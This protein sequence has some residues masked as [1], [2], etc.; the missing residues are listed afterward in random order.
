MVGLP[1]DLGRDIVDGALLEPGQRVAEDAVVLPVAARG[2][3]S[4]AMLR[5]RRAASACH[6]SGADAETHL[7]LHLLDHVIDVG[8]HHVDIVTAPVGKGHVHVRV[9]PQV[10]VL[11]T[12]VGGDAVGVEV[13][14]KD[15]A[16]HVIF[17]DDFFDDVDDAL[18]GLGQAG[19]ED[20]GRGAATGVG[21]Q[22]AR[23]LQFLVLLGIP[24]GAGAPA[25]G[26]HPGVAL[27]AAGM[28]LLDGILQRVVAGITAAGAGQVAGPWLIAGLVEGVAH[29]AHLQEDGIEML[30]LQVVQIG[31]ELGFL[32]RGIVDTGRPVDTI[33]RSDPCGA[34]LALQGLVGIGAGRNGQSN[35]QQKYPFHHNFDI[36]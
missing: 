1:V 31:I 22:H 12:A 3:G 9:V 18:A 23:I 11:G 25:I 6:T 20:G 21:Q 10:V 14:V 8:N 35:K 34:H 4:D 16:V 13:V 32:G 30:G 28:A 19:I 26:I 15:D 24:V 27:D 17:G 2:A 5:C 29:C 7:G 33:D 36:I